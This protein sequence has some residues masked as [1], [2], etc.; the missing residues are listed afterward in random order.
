V[1][2]SHS[3]A[4]ASA[5][6]GTAKARSLSG[7]KNVCAF[8]LGRRC[9]GVDIRIVSEVVTLEAVM[10]VPISPP[11]L[12]GLFN[13]R[14]TPVALIDLARVLDLPEIE[15][16]E[17]AVAAKARSAFVLRPTTL[18]AALLIDRMEIVLPVSREFLTPADA[19]DEH[20]AVL[21]F[22]EAGSRGGLMITV[23]DADILLERFD[24]LK[25]RV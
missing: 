2:D 16:P 3:D 18:T 17:A 1:L 4:K 7:I 15:R 23:L 12:L 9:F 19:A 24:Q 6:Q 21:G 5:A 22:F 13:L 20:P 10:P 25:F 8:W 14:G 11:E